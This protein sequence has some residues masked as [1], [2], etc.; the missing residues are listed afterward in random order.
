MLAG[1]EAGRG[2]GGLSASLPARSALPGR[3]PP[4]L[5]SSPRAGDAPE[6]SQTAMSETYGRNR[7]GDD[8][9]PLPSPP[10]ATSG[11][12]GRGPGSHLLSGGEAAAERGLRR[13]GVRSAVA[14]GG[15]AG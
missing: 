6:M 4:P 11:G 8:D 2:A 14:G 5:S 1:A 13:R 3:E 12:A 10:P 15:S 9:P 7:G